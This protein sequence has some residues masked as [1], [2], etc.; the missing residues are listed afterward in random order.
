MPNSVITHHLAIK[1]AVQ[2][3]EAAL[4]RENAALN[5]LQRTGLGSIKD[6][7]ETAKI[8]RRNAYYDLKAAV[9]ALIDGG[10]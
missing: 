4:G 2:R 3:I 1:S 7:I 9:D 6:T 8:Q 5:E 10:M